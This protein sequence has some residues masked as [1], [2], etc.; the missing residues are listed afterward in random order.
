MNAPLLLVP[1]DVSRVLPKLYQGSTPHGT[2]ETRGWAYTLAV[3]GFDT[4]V[5]CSQE[6]QPPTELLTGLEVLR[7]P[8]D[9][10]FFSF[11][12]TDF[13]RAVRT[14]ERVARRVRADK[15]VLVVCTQG[16]NRSGLVNALALHMLTGLSGTA[17]VQHVR[18][19]RRHALTNPLFV[20]RLRAIR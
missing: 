18:R 3:R 14:A 6:R 10:N 9:D 20:R 11:P 13:R 8:L 5:L 7:C 4:V 2:A 15:R 12:E 19:H 1:V 16:R 17:C